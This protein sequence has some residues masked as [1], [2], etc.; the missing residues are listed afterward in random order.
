MFAPN[1]DVIQVQG[2]CVVGT[3]VGAS[4]YVREYVR[5][6]Y[7]TICKDVETLRISEDLLIRLHLVKFCMN[8]H[9]PFL[10]RNVTPDNMATS[11]ADPTHKGPVHVDQKICDVTGCE[12]RDQRPV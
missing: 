2:L 1:L 3:P 4:Q 6:K 5:N 10:S 9:L 11:S 8:M 7:G 12:N